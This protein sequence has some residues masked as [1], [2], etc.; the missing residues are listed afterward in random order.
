MADSTSTFSE[1]WYRVANQR[2]CLRAGVQV[3]RQNFRGERWYVL[4]NPFTNEYFR[5]RP[6]AYEF[7][8]RLDPRR[9]VE[10]VWRECLEKHPDDA[11]GQEAVLQ[12]L[13]QLYFAN[14]LQYDQATDT[15]NLFD[16]FKKR[17]Q[18]EWRARLLNIMFMRF[19]LLDPDRWLV[20]AL[21]FVGK[22]IS[23]FG[24]ILWLV[25]VGAGIKVVAENWDAAKQQSQGILTPENLPLLYLG[26]I[27]IKTVHEFGHAF[28]CR[29]F[30]GEVHTMGIMLMIFTPVPYVD[31]SSSWGF[32]SRWRRILVGAAGMIVEIFFAA[33]LAFLWA[34][35]GQ[36]TV[37]SLAYNM[38]FI[39]SVSTVIFNANPLLRFDG[40]YIL[41]D[42]ID[43]PN[44][45]QRANNHLRHLS[46]RWLFG[47]T[48]SE[49]PARTRSEASW[50]TIFG[51]TSGVYRLFVFAGILVLVADQFFLIGMVMAAV[52][53]VSW[54][55]VPVF[56]FIQYL[57]SSPKLDRQRPR[58]IAVSV[59][60]LALLVGILQFTPF[61]SHFRAPGVVQ[62]RQWTQV[63]N[64]TAGTVAELLAPPGQLVRAGQPLVRLESQELDFSIA[65]AQANQVEV[66]TRL[67]AVMSKDSANI[68]PLREL[69]DSTTNRVAKLIADRNSLIV[70]ARHDGLWIAPELKEARTRWLAR[71]TPMGLLVNPATYQFTATVRQEE[72]QALFTKNL[73]G[74]EIRLHGEAG[75]VLTTTQWD[76]I[77]GGQRNLPSPALGWQAGGE[78]PLAADDPQGVKSAEPFF[79]VRASLPASTDIALL[80]GRSGK[81]R[82][83]QPWEPLLPRWIRSLRQM[84]QKR[85]QL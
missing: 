83:D 52:C 1:S 50:L 58:A 14:L 82:F 10:D 32:R 73:T 70:R 33:I 16:R 8:A 78:M 74:A 68:K 30:G 69:L 47:L 48:K 67:R 13:A 3:R 15:A 38:M 12:L 36:G 64:E 57:A 28:F 45:T 11:P 9:T 46:E 43:I 59:A 29:K 49:S 71:G 27:L 37:H 53:F 2:I 56:K 84:L 75:R 23:V 55:T 6:A 17:Q 54:V 72:A 66:E 22:F 21:P 44:L 26:M 76:V 42:L 65:Q 5:I 51:S 25:V 34:N 24:A 60:L 39:A 77:P 7:V 18:R 85:Y 81:I 35:T 31:A 79:E 19:P 4:E 62:S 20:R 41:S 80:H 63:V 61:P 40:Y